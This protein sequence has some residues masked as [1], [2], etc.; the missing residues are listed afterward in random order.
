MGPRLFIIFVNT[1]DDVVPRRVL[2]FADDIWVLRVTDAEREQDAFQS[3]FEKL[4]Q[5]SEWWQME[6]NFT[7]CRALL[8]AYWSH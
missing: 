3:D 8:S 5:R 6:F 2:K 1:I 4:V 7:K